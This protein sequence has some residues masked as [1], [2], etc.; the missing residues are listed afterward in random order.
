MVAGYEAFELV[1]TAV[2]GIPAGEVI[3]RW[4]LVAGF[5]VFCIIIGWILFDKLRIIKKLTD[6]DA[7]RRREKEDLELQKLRNERDRG[8]PFDVH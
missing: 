1:Q 3:H 8:Y 2:S 5:F 4:D 6:E 7:Q